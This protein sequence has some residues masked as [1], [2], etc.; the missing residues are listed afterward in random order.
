[1]FT[2]FEFILDSILILYFLYRGL[3]S[4]LSQ[5]RKESY[6]EVESFAEV[7]VYTNDGAIV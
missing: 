7:D 5:K 4:S 2:L 1:M 3:E 6:T